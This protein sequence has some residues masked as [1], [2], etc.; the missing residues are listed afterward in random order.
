MDKFKLRCLECGREI[1]IKYEYEAD[2]PNRRE[3]SEL[4][5]VNI[6]GNADNEVIIECICGN[7][8]LVFNNKM[9]K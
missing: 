9:M 6:V 4:D 1:T 5:K 3:L 2:S 7:E 8:V